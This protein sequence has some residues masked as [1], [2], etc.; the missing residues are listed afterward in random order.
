MKALKTGQAFSADFKFSYNVYSRSKL[1][2][3]NFGITLGV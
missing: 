1:F 3:L 2:Q